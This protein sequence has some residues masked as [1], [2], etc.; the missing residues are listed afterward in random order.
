MKN[1]FYAI[2]ICICFLSVDRIFAQCV[3][4]TAITVPGIYPDSATGLSNGVVSQLYNQVVQ[5]RVPVDTTVVVL[6]SPQLVTIVQIKVLSF[7]NLPPGLSYTTTP[8]TGIYPGGTNGCVEISGT[9]TTAGTYNLRAILETT[10]TYIIFPIVRQDTVDYYKITIS[11]TSTGLANNKQAI[12]DV[13]QNTPNPFSDITNISFTSPQRNQIDFRVF[14]LL[15]KEVYRT[16]IDANVGRNNF[17]FDGRDLSPGIY[18]YSFN[19]GAS[20]VTKRMIISRK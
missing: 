4:N 5:V 14:N 12:F 18:I 3:P 11:N 6:G 9:P 20:S 16:M 17:E 2:L 13:E 8:S 1:K 7:S 10:G 15:G 19:Q